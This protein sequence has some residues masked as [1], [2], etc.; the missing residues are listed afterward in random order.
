MKKY[1][2][3][4]PEL[5]PWYRNYKGEIEKTTPTK[6][7]SYGNCEVNSRNKV[8]INELPVGMWTD[9]FKEYLEDLV[10]NKLIGPVKNYCT[11]KEVNFVL[12][13]LKNG[14]RCNVNTLKMKTFLHTS[15]MVL[16]TNSG[17]LKKFEKVE[18]IIDLFCQVRLKYY[19]KRKIHLLSQLS[20]EL[21]FIENKRRFL[22]KVMKDELKI[23]RIEEEEIIKQLIANDFDKMSNSENEK[24]YDYLL[25]MNIRS[26][27]KDKIEKMKNDMI[28]LNEKIQNLEKIPVKQLWINDLNQ[29]VQ[30][31]KNGKNK[32]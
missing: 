31:I 25:N 5:I 19:E 20:N 6:Y 26:F 15:N 13:E 16:F 24:S 10:E 23:Y 7:T 17:T 27:T 28:L 18:E 30:N 3:I 32:R 4:F 8:S 21:K 14:I 12:T 1:L 2:K 22:E 11:P 9:K 29:F